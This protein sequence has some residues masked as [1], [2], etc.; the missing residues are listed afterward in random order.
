MIFIIVSVLS[1]NHN[2]VVLYS[3]ELLDQISWD[4]ELKMWNIRPGKIGNIL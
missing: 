3:V 2:S 1:I 4:S